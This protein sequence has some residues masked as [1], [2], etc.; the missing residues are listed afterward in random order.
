MKK[1]LL[2]L[3]T[4]SLAA[5]LLAC[6]AAH[7]PGTTAPPPSQT[8]VPETTVPE[9][10]V[11][12]T[13]VPVTTVPETTA[14]LHSDLYLEDCTPHMLLSYWDEVVLQMEYSDG[15]GNPALVQKWLF[16][17]L[18]RI[19]GEPTAEDLRVLETFFDQLNRIPGFPGIAMATG[20]QQENLTLSF[21][22]PE[23]F[24]DRFSEV[25]GGED[26]W[27]ATEFWY[28]TATN[29]IY[30]ARIGYRTDIDQ[31][32]RSSILLEE[33]VNTLGISDTVLREDSIVYQYSDS[34]LQLSETDWLI[35]K[36]L[37]HPDMHCGV[38]AE[39]SHAVIETL[40][41]PCIH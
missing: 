31:L 32:S 33:I 15:T 4:L 2:I 22:G 37:Y 5:S 35:L 39:A 14:P 8:T 19:E 40:Y 27:G 20:N 18:Y 13:T 3:M 9:T 12:E 10:S 24:R 1:L 25:V 17:I 26:A 41:Q 6:G 7:A 16:P 29:E 38:D 11:P 30:T 34:N 21:L 28:Y 36:L 23:D